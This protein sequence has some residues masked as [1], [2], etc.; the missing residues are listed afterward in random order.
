MTVTDHQNI[1]PDGDYFIQMHG[2]HGA[3]IGVDDRQKSLLPHP[4]AIV[5]PGALGRTVR[6]CL[7]ELAVRTDAVSSLQW[8][9]QRFGESTYVLKIKGLGTIPKGNVIVALE[10]QIP[11]Q[12]EITWFPQQ[13]KN[14][15]MCV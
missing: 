14:T 1:L 12:W 3:F 6:N 11:Q 8:A 4:V 7:Q 15:Y 5:P 2:E 9:L 10:T 13:G